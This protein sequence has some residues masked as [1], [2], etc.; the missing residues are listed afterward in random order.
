MKSPAESIP[1]HMNRMLTQIETN[2]DRTEGTIIRRSILQSIQ[3][4]HPPHCRRSGHKDPR[5][6]R[7]IEEVKNTQLHEDPYYMT[8]MARHPSQ[9]HPFMFIR[10]E[11][12]DIATETAM[13]DGDENKVATL[14]M[15]DTDIPRDFR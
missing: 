5:R 12:N 1:T 8:R 10:G 15:W 3:W 9:N 11:I 7:M 6:K 4:D 2:L 14:A 13:L